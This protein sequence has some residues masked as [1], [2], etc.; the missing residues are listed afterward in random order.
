MRKQNLIYQNGSAHGV[1]LKKISLFE[2][3]RRLALSVSNQISEQC[4][5]RDARFIL[6]GW[7]SLSALCFFF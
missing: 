7:R 3:G 2:E 5:V 1:I 6:F 4:C